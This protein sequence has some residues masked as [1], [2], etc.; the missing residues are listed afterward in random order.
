[1]AGLLVSISLSSSNIYLL[2]NTKT[3]LVSSDYSLDPSNGHILC[4]LSVLL[5]ETRPEIHPTGLEHM[6]LSLT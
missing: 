3:T 2:F 4:Y 1:M 6:V 5:I